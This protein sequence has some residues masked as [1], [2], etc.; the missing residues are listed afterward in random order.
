[1]TGFIALRPK[2]YAFK[3]H[4][5]DEYK[6]FKGTAKNAVQTKFKYD[7]YNHQKQMKLCIGLLTVSVLGVKAIRYIVWIL[8]K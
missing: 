8:Q 3:I 4:R 2:C 6:K 1:M 5:D 7:D